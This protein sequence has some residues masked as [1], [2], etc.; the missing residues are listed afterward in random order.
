MKSSKTDP[1]NAGVKIVVEVDAD[2]DRF[3][4]DLVESGSYSSADQVVQAALR[5]LEE[6][7]DQSGSV[8]RPD[9]PSSA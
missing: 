8:T 5:L 9:P 2:L 1:S 6:T 7:E 3:V 4:L